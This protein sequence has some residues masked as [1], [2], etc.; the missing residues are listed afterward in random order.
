MVDQ[1]APILSASVAVHA[2]DA[3][4]G[5]EG[6]SAAQTSL[7]Q[8]EALAGKVLQEPLNADSTTKVFELLPDEPMSRSNQGPILRQRVFPEVFM[9]TV[10]W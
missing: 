9:C 1:S 6:T 7:A 3:A 4:K 10:A 8:A 2:S 5:M